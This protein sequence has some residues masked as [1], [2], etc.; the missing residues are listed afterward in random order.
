MQDEKF[1]GMNCDETIKITKDKGDV[2]IITYKAVFTK[3]VN[4]VWTKIIITS[5]SPLKSSSGELVDFNKT[6]PQTKIMDF[7]E[8]ATTPNVA[9]VGVEEEEEVP[10]ESELVEE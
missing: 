5:N 10:E 2:D 6:T 3:E 8:D 7:D 4:D 9:A 1:I